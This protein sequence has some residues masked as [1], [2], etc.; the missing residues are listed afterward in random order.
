MRLIDKDLVDES[1]KTQVLS[2]SN[3]SSQYKAIQLYKM[4]DKEVVSDDST[5]A[6]PRRSLLRKFDIPLEF[7]DFNFVEKCTKVKD[8]E[9]ILKVLR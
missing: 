1:R 4:L 3:L 5:S 7:L 2:W 6:G 8:I 9:K